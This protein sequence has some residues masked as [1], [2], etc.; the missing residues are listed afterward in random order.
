MIRSRVHVP[1]L[2]AFLSPILLGCD[3]NPPTAPFATVGLDRASSD[4]VSRPRLAVCPTN[5]TE[6]VSGV[7][8]AAGGTLEVAGHRLTIPA[9]ALTHPG[10]FTL[11]APAG[12]LLEVVVA[13]RAT[14]PSRLSAPAAV[15]IS[16]ARC[17]RQNLR[18]LSAQ[19]SS[20]DAETGTTVA[21][22]DAETD[23]AL[24]TV[25]FSADLSSDGDEVF[26]AR[27]IYAVAY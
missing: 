26:V 22:V 10:R 20:L 12:R 19:V 4:A 6:S 21:S 2:I 23:P 11:T 17:K 5:T 8:G 18:L 27:G 1:V 25:T 15:T 14:E 3:A 9:G 13:V 7:I 16:Y 24:M